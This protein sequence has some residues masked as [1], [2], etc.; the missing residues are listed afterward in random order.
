MPPVA[1]FGRSRPEAYLKAMIAT[2]FRVPRK[3]IL[4]S[5]GSYKAKEELLPTV[6]TLI[7]LGFTLYASIGTCDYYNNAHNITMQAVEWPFDESAATPGANTTTNKLATNAGMRSMGDYL[8]NKEFDLVINLPMRGSGAYRISG[9]ITHGYRTRR[10]AIDN[11]IPLI[12]DIKCA[13]LLVLALK[14]VSCEH[15]VCRML[16]AGSFGR[17]RESSA[18]TH[19]QHHRRPDHPSARSNRRP[20]AHA[21]AGRRTQGNMDIGHG[22]GTGRRH[23][24]RTSHAEHAAAIDRRRIARARIGGGS[25]RCTVRLC[26][27]CGRDVDER[28][29]DCT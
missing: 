18:S 23:H 15:V 13:K 11:G 24:V 7:E 25:T 28:D 21:R 4:L 5:I 22:R 19:R 3:S 14:Q 12:T 9:F 16:C 6:R 1:C 17:R 27:V 29:D 2:G 26:T 20:R 8:A 10:M